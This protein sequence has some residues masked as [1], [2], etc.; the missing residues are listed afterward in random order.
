MVAAG[1]D[2]SFCNKNADCFDVI[3]EIVELCIIQ[4]WASFIYGMNITWACP[5]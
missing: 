2:I 1:V 5:P 4:G 3:P